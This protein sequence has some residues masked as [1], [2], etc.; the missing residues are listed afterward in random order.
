VTIQVLKGP[1]VI[2]IKMTHS[3]QFALTCVARS[4]GRSR[5]SLVTRIFQLSE[6]ERET[7]VY[8]KTGRMPLQQLDKYFVRFYPYPMKNK[9]KGAGRPRSFSLKTNIVFRDNIQRLALMHG[10]TVNE[11]MVE[12][13]TQKMANEIENDPMLL[14]RIPYY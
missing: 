10:M 6:Q 14:R 5:T 9:V 11:F 3:L 8:Y 13:L 4:K 2:R 12:T 7:N 1:P